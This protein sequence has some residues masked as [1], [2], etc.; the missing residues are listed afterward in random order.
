MRNEYPKGTINSLM[1]FTSTHDISRAINIFSSD[2]FRLDGQWAWNLKDEDYEK[3]RKFHLTEQ[4]YR[5]GLEIYKSYVFALAFLPGNLSIF[6]GDEI[7]MEGEGNL[8]NRRPFT[9]DKINYDLL[10]YF[11]YIGHIRNNE[12]LLEKAKLEII[13]ITDKLMMFERGDEILT[14]INRTAEE[15]NINLPKEYQKSSK[16]YSIRKTN[17]YILTPHNGLS[18]KK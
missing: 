4:E 2:R 17:K 8:S 6:Y 5:K 14:V 15:I 16:T 1:N 7:G 13:D 10:K 18:I 12:Q 3:S 9:W 11:K